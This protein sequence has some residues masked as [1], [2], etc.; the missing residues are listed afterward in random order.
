MADR[1]SG[2]RNRR[3]AGLASTSRA[4]T[5]GVTASVLTGDPCR[6]VAAASVSPSAPP[7]FSAATDGRSGS[8][9]AARSTRAANARSIRCV[10]AS[11]PGLCQ[12]GLQRAAR[13]LA[14]GQRVADRGVEHSRRAAALSPGA[15]ASSSWPDACSS[16]PARR[17][18]GSPASSSGS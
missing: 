1:T 7:S 4:V 15:T 2:C 16:S 3:R 6:I 18:S 17:S 11:A 8:D 12:A 14:Q 13:Q 9:R 5:A 10:T